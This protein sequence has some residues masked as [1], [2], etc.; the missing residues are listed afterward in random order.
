MDK[1]ICCDD[2][3]LPHRRGGA[4]ASRRAHAVR[5]EQ[6]YEQKDG[7]F[8]TLHVL[9]TGIVE[10]AGRAPDTTTPLTVSLNDPPQ[11][12]REN[13]IARSS[14]SSP[15]QLSLFDRYQHY[16]RQIAGFSTTRFRR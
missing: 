8:V 5:Y 14:T 11:V 4:S 6:H 2:G 9:G 13:A 10:V 1:S 3:W 12:P 7:L 16:V 15:Q